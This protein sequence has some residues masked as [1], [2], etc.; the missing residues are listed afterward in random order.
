MHVGTNN[1]LFSAQLVREDGIGLRFDPRFNFTECEDTEFFIRAWES[2]A[3]IVASDLPVI[4]E[5]VPAERC[6]Y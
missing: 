5:T 1:V 4:F 3:H 6:T 2:G